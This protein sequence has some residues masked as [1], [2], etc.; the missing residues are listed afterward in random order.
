MTRSPK[1]NSESNSVDKR[2]ETFPIPVSSVWLTCQQV[3]REQRKSRYVAESR[4]HPAKML[5]AVAAH[6]IATYS[7]PGDLVLDPMCGVGTTLVEAVH[8]GREAIGMDLEAPFTSIATPTSAS[9]SSSRH[10]DPPAC[11]P[12]TPRACWRSCRRGWSA[13]WGWC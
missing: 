7:K 3:P 5:P 8:Q 13:R 6:A 11:T 10:P 2:S 12:A 9:P 4:N 1:P